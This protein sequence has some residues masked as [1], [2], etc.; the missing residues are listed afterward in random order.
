MLSLKAQYKLLIIN[1]ITIHTAIYA[2]SSPDLKGCPPPDRAEFAFIGRS[3]VGKS[4]LINML[5]NKKGLALTSNKPG[6]TRKFNYFTINDEWYIVDL[7]G[8]GYAQTSHTQRDIWQKNMEAYL[9]KRESLVN[10]FLLIDAN[11]PP[12][13]KDIHFIHWLGENNV[14]FSL[15]FTKSDKPKRIDLKKNIEAMHAALLENWETLPPEF[16]TSSNTALGKEDIL[17]YIKGCL[18]EWKK[19]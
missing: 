17:A 16:I 8:Y 10:V 3:N 4:S 14:P 9:V 6:K 12:Q 1:M 13:K 19:E 5:C 15:V 11:I 2:L 18:S 7:P